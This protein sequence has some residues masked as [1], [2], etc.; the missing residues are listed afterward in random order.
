V[1]GKHINTNQLQVYMN[2]RKAG[3]TQQTAA[4]KAGFSERSGGRIEAGVHQP[5]QGQPRDWRTRTD[6]LAEV[7]SSELEP[8][9]QREPKLEAMTLFEY[10]Q[11]HYP[12]QYQSVLRTVQRRV[13][14]WKAQHGVPPELMFELRHNPGEMGLS[15]FTQLKGVTIT[16]AGVPYEHL[17]YHYRLAYSGWQYVQ[18]IEGGESFIALAEGLQNAL[19]ACGGV[20][21][22]HRTDSLTAAYHN[23]GGKHKLTQRYEAL[24][25]HYRLRS[26]RN[27]TGVAHENGSIVRFVPTRKAEKPIR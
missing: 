16:I 21:E 15:D 18:I 9:L 27:N 10:L 13:S 26:S 8:M 19:I 3:C 1:P 17:L 14:E 5:H 2:A 4:A 7:W 24:C 25:C 22:E 20:P 23:S 11:D 6:P 12:G